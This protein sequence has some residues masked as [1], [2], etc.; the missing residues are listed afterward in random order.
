MITIRRAR[1]ADHPL[2]AKLEREFFRDQREN[3]LK[4]NPKL[5]LYLKRRSGADRFV[6]NRMRKWIRSKNAS[7]FIAEADS[8]PAGFSTVSIEKNFPKLLPKRYGN[9]GYMFVKRQFRGQKI[10]SLMME[11]A[12]AWFASR[13]IKHVSLSVIADNQPARAIWAKWG[14]RDFFVFAWKL[15]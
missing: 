11:N 14:F 1:L 10:S 3:V 13:K 8:K 4:Q 9:I 12:L 7:V 15:E 2:L 5:K 6:D